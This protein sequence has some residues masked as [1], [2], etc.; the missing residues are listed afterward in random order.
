MTNEQIFNAAA[1]FGTTNL[2]NGIEV[3]GQHSS[4]AVGPLQHPHPDKGKFNSHSDSWFLNSQTNEPNL[5]PELLIPRVSN[6]KFLSFV[7]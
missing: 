3:L 4:L 2:W 7:W 1:E 5:F 6:P